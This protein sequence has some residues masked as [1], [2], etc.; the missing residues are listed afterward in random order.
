M[1]T[2]FDSL[3][4]QV[5]FALVQARE[6]RGIKDVAI[7]RIEQLSPFPYDLVRSFLLHLGFYYRKLILFLFIFRL[8]RIWINTRTPAF[9]GARQAYLLSALLLKDK[10]NNMA[11]FIFYRRN[12]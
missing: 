1:F 11:Y 12:H 8:L 4:G 6:D 2:L 9:S 3:I 10:L 7:S 5:Y